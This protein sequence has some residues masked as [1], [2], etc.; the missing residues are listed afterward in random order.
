MKKIFISVVFLVV[1]CIVF[2]QQYPQPEFVN[3]VY[4]LKKGDGNTVV[5]VRLEKSSSQ[6]DTKLK[7]AGFGGAEYGYTIE[8]ESSPVRLSSSQSFSFVYTNSSSASMSTAGRDSILRANGMDPAMMADMGGMSDPA[9]MITLY[10]TEPGK[11][12]RK[13]LLQKSGGMFSANKSSS[14]KKYTFSVK[15]IKEGY[16]E[17][18]PDKPLPRG[19]YAFTLMGAGMGSADGSVMIYAFGIDI[20]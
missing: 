10:R 1:C 17:L 19:E 3:E 14:G 11:G 4:F 7:M 8:S 5:L 2:A 9:S 18:V 13:I 16:W 12:V 20:P 15:K 6:P